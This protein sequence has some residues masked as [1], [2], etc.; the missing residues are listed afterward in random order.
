MSPLKGVG[1]GC[2][3]STAL[4][5]LT[6]EPPRA[7]ECKRQQSCLASPAGVCQAGRTRH[8]RCTWT[9]MRE[10]MY[11]SKRQPVGR[12]GRGWGG[13]G[14]ISKWTLL[15]LQMQGWWHKAA[16]WQEMG[17][18]AATTWGY[19]GR[20]CL[21]PGH[22]QPLRAWWGRYIRTR[23]RGTC[24]KATAWRYWE[25]EGSDHRNREE[26]M[27]LEIPRRSNH[28]CTVSYWTWS[29]HIQVTVQISK[30]SRWGKKVTGCYLWSVAID[31]LTEYPS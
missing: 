19:A 15:E 16:I 6:K 1:E 18:R 4:V 27:D 24:G 10:Q 11:R 7:S 29:A 21:Y 14:P 25:D 30:A 23:G 28:L 13:V 3:E 22:R 20:V 17:P 8:F 12:S 31:V 2:Y 9:A 5:H 26:G